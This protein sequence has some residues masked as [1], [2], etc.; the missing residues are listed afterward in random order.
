MP[1][2]RTYQSHDD[3]VAIPFRDAVDM[4][5]VEMMEQEHCR[6]GSSHV[7]AKAEYFEQSLL[8]LFRN[9]NWEIVVRENPDTPQRVVGRKLP[10]VVA[11][12]VHNPVKHGD[13]VT[14]DRMN[15]DR[16]YGIIGN[17]KGWLRL[18][19]GPG[20]RY[21]NALGIVGCF[22]RRIHEGEL[23]PAVVAE[24]KTWIPNDDGL[25]SLEIH[26]KN[27]DQRFL[28][29]MF[30]SRAERNERA[31]NVSIF[32]LKMTYQSYKLL[33]ANCKG[34]KSGRRRRERVANAYEGE[35]TVYRR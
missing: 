33:L 3:Y 10:S 5:M 2:K 6:M 24:M 8:P 34:R 4:N 32:Q 27:P 9:A 26:A 11:E 25:V 18:Y 1:K 22:E 7:Y 13:I 23:D 29:R 28:R 35:Y 31:G 12:F 20:N 17:D 14:W 19:Y 16:K 21:S 15:G 30:A